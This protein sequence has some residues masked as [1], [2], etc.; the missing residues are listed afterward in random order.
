MYSCYLRIGF[1]ALR[2]QEDTARVM[3]RNG[4]KLAVE[5][6]MSISKHSCILAIVATVVIRP[7]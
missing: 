5:S 6:L 3:L 1:V 4:G 2:K 7:D